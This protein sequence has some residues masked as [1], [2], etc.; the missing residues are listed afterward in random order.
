MTAPINLYV[1]SRI[2]NEQPF[3]IVEKHTSRRQNAGTTKKHEI[4]SLRRL[5]DALISNKIDIDELDGFFFG[6]HIPRIGKE[7]DLLKFT[8]D[9]VLNIELKSQA[10]PKKQIEEQLK[11]N[12]HYLAHLGKKELL[13]TVVT[14]T[15]ICYKL[16]DDAKLKR[17]NMSEIAESVHE[18]KHGY[19]T[20]ID[21]MFRASEF[22][23]SPL[24]TPEKFIN[25]EYF[26]T[27]AQEQ[28]K[29]A[30]LS[31]VL[32]LDSS[33]FISLTGRP[34]T[35][36]TLLIYDMAKE[37]SKKG[38]A[39]IIHCGGLIDGQKKLNQEMNGLCVMSHSDIVSVLSKALSSKFILIDEAH[40][41]D[42]DAFEK[43]CELTKE[44][45]KICIFSSD[46]SQII[47]KSEIKSSI[48][49]KIRA[50]PLR[51]EYKLS[52]RIRANKELVSFINAVRDLKRIQNV[53][54]DMSNIT[55]SYAQNTNEAKEMISYFRKNGYVFINYPKSGN[56]PCPYSEYE[57]DYDAHHV[58][59]Q[60]FDNVLLLMDD[61]FYYDKSKKLQGIPCPDPEYLYPNLFYQG[62]SR[63][64]EKIAVLVVGAPKLFSDITTI[65]KK[66]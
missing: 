39:L 54:T 51:A 31:T 63:V 17:A 45:G 64:R 37:L 24:G 33:G 30:L 38:D 11:K 41:M 3:N 47:S 44:H 12:K 26:L 10:V 62:I 9:S 7:F 22:L 55:L 52:E 25:G 46:P 14:D 1:L 32:S 4:A 56:A 42:P 35:G 16:T 43:I 20:D 48:Y 21:S 36:K 2:E 28:I 58:I 59:G 53:K 18:F 49:R 66:E 61:S 13:Y 50:L 29:K 57:D 23:V 15:M 60:E 65:L 40:R 5:T 27:Q 6:F 34:G 19:L 8:C